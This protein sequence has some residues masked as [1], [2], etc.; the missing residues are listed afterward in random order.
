M[1]RTRGELGA[2][3]TKTITLTIPLTITLTMTFDLYNR[4]IWSSTFC[5]QDSYPLHAL[6]AE[7]KLLFSISFI[8]SQHELRESL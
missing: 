2:P 4:N 7:I 5:I 1:E 6:E 8:T 3:L